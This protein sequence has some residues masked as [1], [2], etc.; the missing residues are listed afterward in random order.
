[1]GGIFFLLDYDSRPKEGNLSAINN[2]IT[3]KHHFN[4]KISTDLSLGYNISRYFKQENEIYNNQNISALAKLNFNYNKY[5]SNL[6]TAF[7]RYI[8][9]K[10]VLYHLPLVGF[11]TILKFNNIYS[12]KLSSNYQKISYNTDENNGGS[13]AYEKKMDLIFL[14]I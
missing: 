2:N 14:V 1:L 12:L 10:D 6:Y 8:K 5:Y 3:Y 13:S 9:N 11:N 7:N 4:N